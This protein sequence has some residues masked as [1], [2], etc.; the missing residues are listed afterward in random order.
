M[1]RLPAS[2][3]EVANRLEEVA[4]LLEAQGAN[5]FRVRAYRRAAETVRHLSRPVAD[6]LAEK[7]LAGLTQLEGI[8]PSLARAIEQLVF[9]GRLALLDRLRGEASG[10]AV[11]AT[12]PGIGRE[13]AARIHEQLGID[14]LTDLEIAAYDGRLATVPGMG[15]KRIRA[16]RESLAG[17]F[18]RR[19][20]VPEVTRKKR[21]SSSTE[22][23]PPV[24]ELLSVDAEYRRKAQ[25]GRL[26]R[27]APRRF[28]PT[29]AAWLPV[30]HTTRGSHHYTALYSNTARAHEVGA[31]NDWVVIY[32][33]DDDSQGQWTVVTARYGPLKGKRVVRGREAECRDYYAQQQRSA[34]TDVSTTH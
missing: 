4:D 12:V 22:A 28:N 19:P 26:P 3:H 10:E 6:I 33:D 29:G 34:A 15:R 9:T 24:A 25:A 21:R 20:R 11:L 31:T 2:N 23:E 5:V 27:I 1:N 16:V 7:G 18:R 8:G 13:M 30:L 32:R 14:N 17:R